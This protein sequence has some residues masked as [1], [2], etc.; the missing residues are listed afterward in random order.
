MSRM[1]RTLSLSLALL[2]FAA[3]AGPPFAAGQGKKGKKEAKPAPAAN[4]TA[5]FEIYKSKTKKG[6]TYRFRLKDGAG[7]TLA[8]ASKGYKTKPE[9]QKVIDIIRA[10]A[11]KAKIVDVSEKK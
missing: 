6:D 5:V 9:C 11:A 2:S 4:G 8:I 7:K 10:H 1:V 3:L